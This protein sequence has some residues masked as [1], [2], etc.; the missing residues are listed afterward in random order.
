M[1]KLKPIKENFS[2][3]FC[4][5]RK[6][7]AMFEISSNEHQKAL[8]VTICQKCLTNLEA[9]I[10]KIKSFFRDVYQVYDAPYCY[11]P[12]G[13]EDSY[14]LCIGGDINS[15]QRKIYSFLDN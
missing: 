9:S 12:N 6:K 8:V 3:N 11:E 5:E 13:P 4:N 15:L 1:I 10:N 2:C 14:H 7:Y